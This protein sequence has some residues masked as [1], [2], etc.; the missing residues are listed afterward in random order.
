MAGKIFLHQRCLCGQIGLPAPGILRLYWRGTR[1]G[2]RYFA[3]S[4][5]GA[6]LAVFWQY[7][8]QQRALL[9]AVNE[10]VPD[11]ENFDEFSRYSCRATLQSRSSEREPPAL[12]RP[13]GCTRLGLIVF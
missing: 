9:L 2:S 3:A 8:K 12:R 10:K 1:W 4:T 6:T 7:V 13:G 5:G 11:A